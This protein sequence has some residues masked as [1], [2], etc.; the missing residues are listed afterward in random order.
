MNLRKILGAAVL[1]AG[2]L[3]LTAC[4]NSEDKSNAKTVSVNVGDVLPTMDSSLNTTAIGAQQLNNTMEGLYRFDGKNLKPAGA[5]SIAKPTNNGTRYTIDLR[6]TKWSNGDNVTAKDYVYAWRRTVA[7]KTGSQYAYI[8]SGV[9]NAE[10]INAGKMPTNTLGIKALN[11]Y[12]LQIDLEHPIAYFN[13]MLAGSQFFPQNEKVVKASKGKYGLNSKNLVSNGPFKLDNWKVSDTT[14][15]ETKNKGYWDAKNVKL[16]ALKYHVVK[17][18]NTGLNLYTSKDLDIYTGLSGD[19]AQQLSNRKDFSTT[20]SSSLFYMELNQAK[21]PLFKNEKIR[22]AISHAIDRKQLSTKVLG[23]TGTPATTVVPKGMAYN[24]KTKKDFKDEKQSKALSE[25][26]SYNPKLATKLWKEGLK[27]VSGGN[28]NITLVSDDTDTAKKS[29]EFLQNGLEKNLPGLKITLNNVPFKNR[30]QKSTSGDFD[31]VI[32]AWSPDYPDPSTFLDLFTKGN[33]MNRGKWSNAQ[34]DAQ[35]KAAAITNAN[36]PQVRWNN[37]LNAQSIITK[38]Q[39]TV[40]LYQQTVA[41]LMN[42]KV[43]GYVKDPSGLYNMANVYK[44]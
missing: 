37:M 36:N 42:D 25:S 14:W 31:M 39:G 38:E 34:Y 21:N 11:D 18:P 23:N 40:P 3:T 33:A 22:Q 16:D 7:P 17:D 27:E 19:S 15:K 10:K 5:T 44:K 41:S 13:S 2:L 6:K 30:L 1:G 8:F 29:S 35:D 20:P 43:Q 24:E 28:K 32:S 26:T 9:K 12:K 4:G